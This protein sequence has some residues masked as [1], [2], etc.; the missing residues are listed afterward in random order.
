M[1][2]RNPRVARGRCPPLP[3]HHAASPKA[4]S[5][6]GQ[7]FR[8]QI[9][10]QME[11]RHFDG[12]IFSTKA[13]TAALLAAVCWQTLKMPTA[14]W[15]A[16]V[17]AVLVTQPSLHSSLRASIMRV[18][19]NLAGAFGGA[20]LSILLGHPFVAMAAGVMITGLVCYLL[21]QDDALRPAF[22]AV[23]IVTITDESL[24]WQGCVNR[25]IAVVVGCLCAVLIGF[26]FDKISGGIKPSGG[27]RAESSGQTE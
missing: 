15:A 26:L 7:K 27:G 11:S 1:P 19:A 6:P 8:H 23:I 20:A 2:S 5:Q 14:P 17:S 4:R 10:L 21:K 12:I 13:A 22:V 16:A 24:R 25:V 9:S 18:I 3:A